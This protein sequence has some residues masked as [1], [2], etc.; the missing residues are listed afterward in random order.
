MFYGFGGL[1]CLLGAWFPMSP[2]LAIGLS[3]FFG[4]V[5]F[6]VAGSLLALRRR[7]NLAALN[8]AI[9]AGTVMVSILIACTG[10]AVGVVLPAVVYLCGALIAAYF[11]PPALA[12]GQAALSAAGFSAGVV[13][14]GVPNLFVPWFVTTVAVVGGA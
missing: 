11:F 4:V 2:H 3:Q 9:A 8:A 7:L 5:S 12:R 6:A 10:A 1:A 13:A 14:S